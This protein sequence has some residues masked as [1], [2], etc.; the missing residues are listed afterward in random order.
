[1]TVVIYIAIAV[2]A[3]ALAVAVT[4][5]VQRKMASSRANQIIAEAE[6]A[7]EDLK[8]D[9][10][11][12]GREEALKITTDAEKQANQKMSKLQSVEAK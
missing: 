7:A 6:R 2:V 11:L 10:V 4:L 1:M 9:K 5:V 8:R 12:E 3:A